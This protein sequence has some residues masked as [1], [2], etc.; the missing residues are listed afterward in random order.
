[1]IG[2][3]LTRNEIEYRVDS[4]WEFTPFP[5][6]KWVIQCPVCRSCEVFI[7]QCSFFKRKENDYRCDV[8]FKCTNCSYV[9][10]HGVVVPRE[11]AKPMIRPNGWSWREMREYNG[12]I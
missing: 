6:P 12:G 11:I 3:D 10:T 2:H 9:W 5:V 1:M 7:K 8:T 4:M